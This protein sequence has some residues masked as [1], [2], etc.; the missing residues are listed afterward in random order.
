MTRRCFLHVGSPK[1]GTSYLQS[2]L[3]Q[4]RTPLAAQGI[5]LPLR[6][7]DHFFLTLQLRGRYNPQVDPPRAAGVLDRL[8]AALARSEGDVL[9]TH[10]LL[11]VVPQRRQV[12]VNSAGSVHSRRRNTAPIAA[13]I[14]KTTPITTA[15]NVSTAWPPSRSTSS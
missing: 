14:E 11:S 12:S 6:R 8:D 1:T 4:S 2:V 9:I 10:E 3:W 13:W 5:T 15:E 7:P